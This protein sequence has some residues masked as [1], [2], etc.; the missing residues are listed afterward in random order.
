MSTLRNKAAA[1]SDTTP[2]K[3]TAT[4]TTPI[5]IISPLIKAEKEDFE[6]YNKMASMN[7][8][9]GDS[10]TI[11]PS[12]LSPEEICQ[13]YNPSSTLSI[14]PPSKKNNYKAIVV[15]ETSDAIYRLSFNPI[16]VIESTQMTDE[17]Y[18]NDDDYNGM[19]DEGGEEEGME[20]DGMEDAEEEEENSIK[21]EENDI[22]SFDEAEMLEDG[23]DGEEDEGKPFMFDLEIQNKSN[24]H[25]LLMEVEATEDGETFI[26]EMRLLK[27]RKLVP[28]QSF[29]SMEDGLKEGFEKL[30]RDNCS[31][32]IPFILDY[33]E[34]CDREFYSDWLKEVGE[35]ASN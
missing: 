6:E 11:M 25:S 26:N 20:E 34:A 29:H 31:S 32:M 8:T 16:S 18:E 24:S 15:K 5:S 13:K 9:N 17:D 12:Q 35:F 14:T 3:K 4:K 27:N 19:E 28:G 30:V 2:T 10:T 33:S 1:T 7:S 22:S 23:D 21:S